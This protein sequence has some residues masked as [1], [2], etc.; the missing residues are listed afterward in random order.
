MKNEKKIFCRYSI[1][2]IIDY[3]DR[4]RIGFFKNLDM[5]QKIEKQT[6]VFVDEKID[7]SVDGEENKIQIVGFKANLMPC[8]FP[9]L[10]CPEDATQ[11]G[12]VMNGLSINSYLQCNEVLEHGSIIFN[13]E[14]KDSQ[15]ILPID[16]GETIKRNHI[17]NQN[18]KKIIIDSNV[19]NIQMELIDNCSCLG[20]NKGDDLVAKFIWKGL[21]SCYYTT[22]E[23]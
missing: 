7:I 22:A 6:A 19:A 20:I 17:V 12:A 9:N 21:F 5:S 23:F 2:G 18:A 15:I 4:L 10:P 11:K 14:G 16:M 1:F 8:D 13:A 3:L